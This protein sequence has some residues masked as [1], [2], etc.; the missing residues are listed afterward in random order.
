[1]DAVIQR[2]FGG[3]ER[4]GLRVGPLLLRVAHQ[5][6]TQRAHV[7]AGAERLVAG[8]AQQHGNDAVILIPDR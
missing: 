4:L 1:M 6:L 5:R 2:V 3:E 7:A 8:A